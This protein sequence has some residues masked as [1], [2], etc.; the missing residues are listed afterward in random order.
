MLDKQLTS[1]TPG[2]HFQQEPKGIIEVELIATKRLFDKIKPQLTSINWATEGIKHHN[3]CSC[4]GRRK[5][6]Q[7]HVSSSIQQMCCREM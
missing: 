3:L 4:M 1:I 5:L 2:W 7:E 6:T